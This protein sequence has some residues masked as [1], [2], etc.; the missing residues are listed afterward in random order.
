MTMLPSIQDI[1]DLGQE[2]LDY[3]LQHSLA[4]QGENELWLEFGVWRGHTINKMAQAHNGTVFGFDSFQGLP[5]D[6]RPGFPAGTFNEGGRLPV[7][8]NNACLVKGWF[9]KTLPG[10]LEA[11]RHCAVSLLHI[12]CDI[13]SS[14]R[15]VL[16]SLV[17][18]F[19]N[20]T[21]VVFD[22][23]I[24]YPGY[25]GE[26]GELRAWAEFVEQFK[27]EF[28]WI[29]MNGRLGQFANPHEKVALKVKG[30]CL[31]AASL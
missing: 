31:D 4:S 18:F 11:H 21:I 7:V 24:N 26:N 25:D 12:D 3:V 8:A 9:D 15:F 23:L 22:E 27:V 20:G 30:L 17:P 19:R 28:E 5:E 29:G 13:Y 10:F 6:W 1:P 2:P 14:T 16:S